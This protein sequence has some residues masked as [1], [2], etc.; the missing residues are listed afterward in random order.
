[1]LCAGGSVSSRPSW[2]KQPLTYLGLWLLCYVAASVIPWTQ[3][4]GYRLLVVLT[5]IRWLSSPSLQAVVSWLGEP[6]HAVASVAAG[7]VLLAIQFWPRRTLRWRG[8]EA[9]ILL[10]GCLA[11]LGTALVLPKLGWHVDHGYFPHEATFPS[12]H[13]SSLMCFYLTTWGIGWRHWRLLVD[14]LATPILL[15][16][17]AAIIAQSAHTLWDVLGPVMLALATRSSLSLIHLTSMT[18]THG[19][20]A[21]MVIAEPH[22]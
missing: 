10:L 4:I 19:S 3:L 6:R 17:G 5:D 7:T 20:T 16:L 21:T 9:V 11:L 8:R 14:I 12:G 15:L 18:P 13:M 2:R 22:Q 1:M